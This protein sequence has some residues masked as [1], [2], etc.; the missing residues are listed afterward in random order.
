MHNTPSQRI[1]SCFLITFLIAS[2]SLLSQISHTNSTTL[3]KSKNYPNN[4]T[5]RSALQDIYKDL[6]LS[7]DD[8]RPIKKSSS[9]NGIVHDK[10]QQYYQNIPIF[11]G[12]YILHSNGD[13]MLSSNGY[14]A[15]DIDLLTDPRISEDD[16]KK[17]A[18]S[19][20][21]NQNFN[22]DRVAPIELVIIDKAFPNISK[23]YALAYK[24]EVYTKPPL[25]K[26]IYFI[27]AHSG[28]RI[29]ILPGLI[30]NTTPAIAHTK[31]HGEQEIITESQDDGSYILQDLTRGDGI[32]TYNHDF[33]TFRNQSTVWDLTNGDKDEVALDAHYAT[34]TFYDMMLHRFNWDGLDGDGKSMNPVV[35]VDEGANIVN[36]FWDGHYAYFG[37][38]DCHR[39]PLTTLEVVAHEF[40]HGI[41][42]YPSDL[43]YSF[44]S[45]AINESMSD[46]FGKATEYYYAPEEFDWQIGESFLLTNLIEPFRYMDDPKRKNM[47]SYYKG[48]NWVDGGGVHSHSA[49]GNLWV[50]LLVEGRSDTTELGHQYDVAGIGMDKAIEIVWQ[51]QSNYLTP[52]SDYVDMYESSLVVASSMFGEESPELADVIEAWKAVGLPQ[53]GEGSS[54]YQYDL[55]IQIDY[56]EQDQCLRNEYLPFTVRLINFGTQNIPEN[57]GIILYVDDPFELT[58]LTFDINDPIPSG[59]SITKK[60][61]DIAYVTEPGRFYLSATAYFELDDNDYNN[62]YNLRP[63]RIDNYDPLYNSL[64]YQLVDVHRACSNDSTFFDVFIEN[65]SCNILPINTPIHYTILNEL[66]DTI[67]ESLLLLDRPLPSGERL[68]VPNFVTGNYT[69]LSLDAYCATNPA[70]DRIPYEYVFNFENKI[71]GNYFNDLS[72]L[73]KNLIELDIFRIENIVEYN[74]YQYF[75]KGGGTQDEVFYPCPVDIQDFQSIQGYHNGYARIGSCVDLSDIDHPVLSFDLIQFRDDS[76]FLPELNPLRCRAKITW[77]PGENDYIVIDNQEEGI[78]VNHKINLPNNFVGNFSIEFVNLTGTWF[79]GSNVEAYLSYDVN[80]IRNLEIKNSTHTLSHI[81]KEEI[82]VAP[83]PG[84][85]LY[86]ITSPYP[87]QRLKVTNTQ[88]QIVATY[89]SSTPTPHTQID[90]SY[91]DHGYYIL[92]LEWQDG[93]EISQPIIHMSR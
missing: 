43:I 36:A 5:T 82:I 29:L 14:L 3:Y 83:N 10:Y 45:G 28:R 38:G 62:N 78:E 86:Q 41:T 7:T 73:D 9:M 91:L 70:I 15:S 12:Q 65:L 92:T 37:D 2:T 74:G 60:F 1:I 80:M 35:H 89:T 68:T 30:H 79:S 49:I 44:E 71:V 69:S 53:I 76:D 63:Y 61:D 48:Q 67:I 66:G 77:G 11:G 34:E 26:N 59:E 16:A 13:H 75:A 32:T 57:S 17:I 87:I 20:S 46:I 40:M 52:S 58:S 47:P 33:T 19:Y 21:E 54:S 84:F 39:G 93:S 27:D 8:L 88:G 24:I 72:D 56:I 55:G 18:Y 25:S 6:K 31:Y 50:H 4:T 22:E 85:G 51:V 90:L 81:K 42:D 64:E 23:K